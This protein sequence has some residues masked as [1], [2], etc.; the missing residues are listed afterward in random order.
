M[1]DQDALRGLRAASENIRDDIIGWRRHLHARPELSGQERETAAFVA[2]RLRE[3][4]LSPVTGVGGS[5]GVYVD[6]PGASGRRVALRAD[7]DALPITE[8]T[9]LPFASQRPG[10]MHAC[11]HDAHTAMLLG[12]ARLLVERRSEL[13]CGV[14]LLFQPHEEKYPGG[15]PAM[16]SGGALEGVSEVFGLHIWTG[17]PVGKLGTRTGGFMCAVNR[18]EITVHGVGGH[19]AMPN[20]AVDPVLIAAAII[21]ALQS[22]VSRGVAPSEFAVVSVTQVE[23]GSADNV[24]PSTA[25]LVGTIRTLQEPVRQ[26]VCRRVRQVV[27]GVAAALGG[28]AEV[29]LEP[30]YPPLFNDAATTERALRAAEAVGF[31]G[32]VLELEP[33]GGAEDFAYYGQVAPSAFVFLGA[34]NEAKDCV[35]SHHHPKFRIDEDA[36]AAGAALHAAFALLPR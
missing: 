21:T 2:E 20:A 22:V 10:V 28:R 24:I 35:Y 32:A 25:R 34:R 33:Q 18:L 27:E 16:I 5:H 14:R 17:V 12:A 36:L 29:M 31:A 15:A 6:I 7:M 26:E 30:G 19:A 1:A 11:G 13:R 23:A 3:L 9:G 8:E 4:G